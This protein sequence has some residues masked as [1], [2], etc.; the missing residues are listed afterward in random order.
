MESENQ[1][2]RLPES[3]SCIRSLLSGSRPGKGQ[4]SYSFIL[5]KQQAMTINCL[6][7]ERGH[8]RF[9]DWLQ[10]SHNLLAY[11]P[12]S[13]TNR[14]ILCWSLFYRLYRCCFAKMMI[15]KLV[16]TFFILLSG[17]KLDHRN[18]QNLGVWKFGYFMRI[19]TQWYFMS[20][21]KNLPYFCSEKL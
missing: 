11:D 17:N 2:K 12:A 10:S 20:G 18:M 14:W 3:K 16:Q 9:P 1:V 5:S 7:Q 4:K 15:L 8:Y 21:L 6:P 19:L 13:C